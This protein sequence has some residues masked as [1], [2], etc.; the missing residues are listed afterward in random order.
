MIYISIPVRDEERTIG[1]LLW[2]VRKVMA[3]FG[4]PYEVMVLDDASTDRTPQVLAAYDGVLPLHVIRSE[5][6]LGYGAAVERLLGA[7]VARSPYPKRDVAITLQGDF[8]E[9]PQDLVGM[10]KTIEGGADL[11]VGIRLPHGRGVPASHRVSRWLAPLV[12]GKAFRGA[13]VRDPLSGF[14]AYRVIVL[15]KALREQD[16]GRNLVAPDGWS[17]NLELLS[18][19]APHARQIAEAPIAGNFL[20]RERASRFQALS[21]LRGLVGLR[22]IVWPSS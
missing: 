4:R 15:K 14:R 13:P 5:K 1:V 9:D 3:A 7:I 11:V 2:K 16:E 8:T 6:P 10:V 12:L 20:W 22:R 17:A 18:R 19:V 21:S